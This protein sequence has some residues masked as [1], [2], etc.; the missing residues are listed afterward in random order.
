MDLEKLE[1]KK[2]LE[3]SGESVTETKSDKDTVEKTGQMDKTE[4]PELDKNEMVK[5]KDNE[6]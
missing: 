5:K 3:P 2:L 1:I 6:K 4:K